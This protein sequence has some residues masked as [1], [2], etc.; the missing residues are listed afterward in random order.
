[1][2]NTYHI[3]NGDA[4]AERFPK[5]LDGEVIVF[6]ECLMEGPLPTENFF[7]ARAAYLE[8]HY[9]TGSDYRQHVQPELEKVE[10]IQN[11]TVYLWFKKDL[12]CQVN[13]WYCCSILEDK[14]ASANLVLAESLNFGFGGYETDQLATLIEK[15]IPLDQPQLQILASCWKAFQSGEAIAIDTQVPFTE[16]AVQARSQD[17]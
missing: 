1:M 16:T 13:L 12:F 8:T 7:E 3:L 5:T 14:G 2:N 17:P 9:P 4:L 6:R 11:G 10:S 15:T